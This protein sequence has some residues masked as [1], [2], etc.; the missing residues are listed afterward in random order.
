MNALTQ[1]LKDVYADI[2]ILVWPILLATTGIT[3]FVCSG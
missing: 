1:G 2:T 3:I